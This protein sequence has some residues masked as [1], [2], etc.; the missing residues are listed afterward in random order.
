MER[1]NSIFADKVGGSVGAPLHCLRKATRVKKAS[2]PQIIPR[3]MYTLL[4]EIL[5]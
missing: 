5:V 4:L 1:V 3:T 2:L